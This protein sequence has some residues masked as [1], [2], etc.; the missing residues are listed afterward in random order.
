MDIDYNP[1]PLKSQYN[2]DKHILE[3][4]SPEDI[5]FENFRTIYYG[6]SSKDLNLCHPSAYEY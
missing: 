2:A 5:G 3:L 6:S 1:H 4:S